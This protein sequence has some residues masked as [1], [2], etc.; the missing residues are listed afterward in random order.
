MNWASRH[1][2][3]HLLPRER[4]PAQQQFTVGRNDRLRSDID[5]I[6]MEIEGN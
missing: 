3:A 4:L 6:V 2:L 5:A 1:A